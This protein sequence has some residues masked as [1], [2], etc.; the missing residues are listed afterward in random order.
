MKHFNSKVFVILALISI[1]FGA[2]EAVTCS[3]K[4]TVKAGDY[5]LKISEKFGL[6]NKLFMQA[7]G[8][9]P[10]CTNLQVNIFA[11]TSNSNH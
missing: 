9:Q 3:E 4:Y 11:F 5:C 6:D 8:I 1:E 10:D 2:N 7:N